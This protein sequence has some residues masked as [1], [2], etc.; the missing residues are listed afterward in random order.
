LDRNDNSI[1][2]AFSML[3]N[4][5][6]NLVDEVKTAHIAMGDSQFYHLKKELKGANFKRSILVSS[7]I[8]KGEILSCH[9]IRVARPGDGL[10]PSLWRHALGCV[11]KKDME[12]G[13]PISLNDFT[14]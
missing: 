9:N 8:K 7:S 14:E 11:A 10:C 1:D 13:Y 6:K 4:E 5:F 3:P 12:V 2:G